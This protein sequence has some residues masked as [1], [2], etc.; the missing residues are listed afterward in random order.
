MPEGKVTADITVSLDGFVAGPNDSEIDRLHKWLYDLSS[1]REMHGLEGG[2]ESTD[3]EVLDE[4]FR[5]VGALILGR[6]MFDLADGWGEEP[7]FHA[8]VFVLTHHAREPLPKKGGTTFTFVT[9]GI[10]SALEQARAAAGEKDVSIAGGAST[11]QQF[12]KAGLLDEIQI[13]VVPVLL[14]DG[15]PLFANLGA[16]PIELERTRV[17]ESPDVVHIRFRFPSG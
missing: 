15:I 12:I 4:A 5:N 7:P 17:I 8:P 14:G 10:E 16:G 2:E 13:H 9:E 11:I 6:R 3:A 1:W